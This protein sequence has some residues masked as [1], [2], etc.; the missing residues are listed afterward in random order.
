VTRKSPIKHPVKPHTR[1]GVHVHHYV[2]GDG[3]APKAPRKVIGHRDSIGPR[4]TV[5]LQYGKGSE[6][7]VVSASSYGAALSEG[8][9]GASDTPRAVTMR[10]R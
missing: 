8:L 5:T 7:R 1:A 2:R 9:Q 6:S 10:R 3:E 4:F